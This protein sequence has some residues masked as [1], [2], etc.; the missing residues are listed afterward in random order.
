MTKNDYETVR[1]LVY[2]HSRINLGTNKSELVVARLTK[3]VRALALP[4]IEA[5][6]EML[7]A[8]GGEHEIMNLIDVISTN[9]TYFF[10]EPAH[11]TYLVE[12]VL[13]K[14]T[15]DPA[16]QKERNL[17]VWS[18]ACS[19]GEEPYTLAVVL[20]DYFASQPQWKWEIVA[21]DISQP[22]LARAREG[23]YTSQAVRN[24]PQAS[25]NRYFTSEKNGG[26]RSYRVKDE[27]AKRIT[28]KRLNLLGQSYSAKRS[29]DV[30][31]C[32]NVMI[33]F[34]QPTQQELVTRLASL[35]GPGGYFFIGHSENL[36]STKHPLKL[37]CPAVYYRP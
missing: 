31:F 15:Q 16:R 14:L 17:R 33:Y 20:A 22:V 34:D 28:F 19:S 7:R 37:A 25:L 26:A 4:S 10:R 5:Y 21:T 11:F 30:I 3:R 29:F 1:M 18:A 24:V 12:K 13:P 32:R 6:C 9:H 35:L 23:E 36:T 8:P 27:L 2:E